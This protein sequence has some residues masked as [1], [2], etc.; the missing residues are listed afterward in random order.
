MSI[1]CRVT[2]GELTESIHVVFAVVVNESGQIFSSGDPYHFTCVRSTLKPFQAAAAVKSGAVDAANF[3][4]KELAIMCASHYGEQ[5]H[6][7]TVEKMI[8]KLGLSPD[9]FECGAHYPS[10]RES[11]HQIIKNNQAPNPFHNN[12][13]GKHAGMLAFAQ[14]LGSDIKGY[15]QKDHP[16]QKKIKQLVQEISGLE[17]IPTEID[18]CSAPTPFMTLESLAIMFQKLGS[19]EYEELNRVFNAMSKHPMMIGGTNNFDTEFIEALHGRGITKIGG[20]SI[21][22]ITL[23]TKNGESIGIALKVLD[24]NFRALPVA[25]MTLLDHLKLLSDSEAKILNKFKTKIIRNHNQLE[26]GRIE[27]TVE[28]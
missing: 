5:Y 1:L 16:V 19:G 20:E 27:A 9:D 26:I 4:E 12:C 10:D 15:V 2:R 3:S 22:G 11:R 17:E 14:Y 23:K 21:R 6:I 18:G 13:S 8:H 28:I 24:G 25:T 7:D